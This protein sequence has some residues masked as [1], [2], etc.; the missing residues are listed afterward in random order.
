MNLLDCLNNYIGTEVKIGSKCAFIYCD[1]VPENVDAL[2]DDLSTKELDKL[3]F[4]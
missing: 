3:V 1:K 4:L 2:L